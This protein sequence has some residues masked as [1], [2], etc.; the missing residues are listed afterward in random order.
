MQWR[1]ELERTVENQ[2]KRLLLLIQGRYLRPSGTKKVEAPP[3]L[4]HDKMTPVESF[5]ALSI[6]TAF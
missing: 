1:G 4:P 2:G 5:A 3:L 6:L